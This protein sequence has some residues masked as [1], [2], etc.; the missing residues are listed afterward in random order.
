MKNG[1]VK[2]IL[3]LLLTLAMLTALLPQPA[4][5]AVAHD[6]P[7]WGEAIVGAAESAIVRVKRVFVSSGKLPSDTYS[8]L[9]IVD[10]GGSV[11]QNSTGWPTLYHYNRAAS[12][13]SNAISYD[14]A[15]NT[16]TLNNYN[17]GETF[18]AANRMGDLTINVIGT[19][20]LDGIFGWGDRYGMSFHLIGNGTLNLTYNGLQISGELGDCAISIG[21]ELTLTSQYA[22]GSSIFIGQSSSTSGIT[23]PVN[24]DGVQVETFRYYLTTTINGT[25]YRLYT[26]N[27]TYYGSFQVGETYSLFQLNRNGN[28][29]TIADNNPVLSNVAEIPAE[30]EVYYSDYYRYKVVNESGG[31]L[32][33]VTISPSGTTVQGAP[34]ILTDTVLPNGFVGRSCAATLSATPYAE[35]AALAWSLDSG[36]VP[37]GLTL[38]SDGTFSGT[39]AKAGTYTFSAVVNETGGGLTKRQF[40]IVV[41]ETTIAAT[42]LKPAAYGISYSETLTATPANGGAITWALTAG[43]LPAGLG[44]SE[45]GVISG[46]PT[47]NGSSTFTV[48]ATE[49]G[50]GVASKEFT[51]TVAEANTV[52]YDLAGGAGASGVNYD[53]TAIPSGTAI[54]LPAAPTKS[55]EKGA[56]SFAGWKVTSEGQAK[57]YVYNTDNAFTVNEN[58][59]FTAQWER[60]LSVS[61]SGQVLGWV[62]LY[63]VSGEERVSLWGGSYNTVQQSVSAV[64]PV[65]QMRD[66]SYTSLELHA[67]VD[68]EDTVIASYTGAVNQT[69]GAVTLTDANNYTILKGVTVTGLTREADYYLSSVVHHTAASANKNIYLYGSPI[70]VSAGGTY[71]VKLSG[72]KGSASYDKY[73]WSA[74]NGN[75]TLSDG[76]LTVAPTAISDAVAVSGTVTVNGD[77]RSGVI[78]TAT[79]NVGGVARSVSATTESGGGYTLR[80]I[81]GYAATF[82]VSYQGQQLSVTSGAEMAGNNVPDNAAHSI[83]ALSNTLTVTVTP[84]VV[85]GNETLADSYLRNLVRKNNWGTSDSTVTVTSGGSGK[86]AGISVSSASGTT[87]SYSLD[88]IK[89]N[90]AMLSVSANVPGLAAMSNNSVQLTDS[91][92]SVPFTPALVPGVYV[93]S[94]RAERSADV[95]TAWYDANGGYMGKSERFTIST[96]DSAYGIPCPASNN[97]GAF[98]VVLLPASYDGAIEG[99]AYSALPAGAELTSWD[100]TLEAGKA[101]QMESRVLSAAASENAAFV[102]KPGSTLTASAESFAS[103]NDLI[104]F[105]GHIGLDDG[106]KNGRLTRLYANMGNSAHWEAVSANPKQLVIDGKSYAISSISSGSQVNGVFTFDLSQENIPLPCDYTLYCTPG[107]IAWEMDVGLRADVTYDDGG[108]SQQLIG[109]AVVEKPGAYI[110]TLST[111]VCDEQIAV[112]GTAKPNEAVTIYDNGAIAGTA[113]ADKYG[114]WTAIIDLNG[115]DT[116]YVTTH[117]IHSVSAAGVMSDEMTVFHQPGGAQLTGFTMTYSSYGSGITSNNRTV[118]VGDTYIVAPGGLSDVSFTVTVKNPEQ[119]KVLPEGFNRKVTVKVYTNDGQIRFVDAK[120]T[121]TETVDGATV[122]TFVA[123]VGDLPALV[124][125]AE[126]LMLPVTKTASTL[127]PGAKDNKGPALSDSVDGAFAA[128]MQTAAKNIVDEYNTQNHTNYTKIGEVMTAIARSAPTDADTT[129]TFDDS[130]K[131]SVTLTADE[132]ETYRLVREMYA[133]QDKTLVASNTSFHNIASTTAFLNTIGEEAKTAVASGTERTYN[134]QRSYADKTSLDAAKAR[135]ATAFNAVLGSGGDSL[136]THMGDTTN[137]YDVYGIDDMTYDEDNSRWDGTYSISVAYICDEADGL[138]TEVITATFQNGFSGFD[139]GHATLMAAGA[140]RRLQAGLGPASDETLTASGYAYLVHADGPGTDPVSTNVQVTAEDPWTWGGTWL[141]LGGDVDGFTETLRAAVP[142]LKKAAE[143]GSAIKVPGWAANTVPVAATIM[144][145]VSMINGYIAAVERMEQSDQW[146]KDLDELRSKYCFTLLDMDQKVIAERY[147]KEFR[148]KAAA[149][150]L[151][152]SVMEVINGGSSILGAVWGPLASYLN[153]ASSLVSTAGEVLGGPIVWVVSALLALIALGSGT[154]GAMWAQQAQDAAYDAYQQ[155]Y[156]V[157]N[158]MIMQKALEYEGDD[159]KGEK[160]SK[161]KIIEAINKRASMGQ[162][163]DPSGIVYEGVIENPVAGATATLYYAADNNNN[164]VKESN[165]GSA[166]KLLVANGVRGVTPG[167]PV[168]TTSGDGMFQWFVPEGLWF[169]TAE[170]GALTGNSNGDTAATVTKTVGAATTLLPVLPPQLD[171]NIPL[172]DHSVPYVTDVQYQTDGIYVTFSKYMVDTVSGTNSALNPANYSVYSVSADTVVSV[173]SVEQGSTP[174]NRGTPTTS[175]TRT[176][177]LTTNGTLTAGDS[178]TLTVNNAKSYAGTPMASYAS[179]SGIVSEPDQLAAPVFSGTT[180]AGAAFSGSTVKALMNR[181][182]G[183]TI[184]AENGAKIYYTTDGTDPSSSEDGTTKLYSGP[185]AVSGSMTVKAIAVKIGYTA[186]S[187]ATA[188]ITQRTAGTRSDGSSISDEPSPT[189]APTPTPTPTPSG[190]SD[191]ASGNSSVTVPVSGGTGTINLNV[192]VS[193]GTA[194]VSPI[195]DADVARVVGTGGGNV[196]VVMNLSS[197]GGK[198]ETVSIPDASFDKLSNALEAHNGNDSLT[199]KTANGSV[200]LNEAAASAVA[201]AGG[202]GNV[203]FTIKN[204][205]ADSFDAARRAAVSGKTVAGAYDLGVTSNGS[206][207]GALGGGFAEINVSFAPITGTKAEDHRVYRADK[208]GNTTLVP[209]AVHDGT[210]TVRSDRLDDIVIVYEPMSKAFADIADGAYYTD[211]LTWALANEITNGVGDNR[212]APNGGCTRAQIVTFL[213]RAAGSPQP[214][215]SVSGFADVAAGTWYSS[216]V[217]WAVENG[218]TNGVG[219]GLFG[220]EQICTRAQVATFLCRMNGGRAKRPPFFTDVPGDAWYTG[221]VAWANENGVTNGTSGGTFSPDDDCT[222]GQIVTFLYRDFVK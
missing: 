133:A 170:K 140:Q 124:S 129:V 178:V 188:E 218:I 118:N 50:G 117:R 216:A 32:N 42:S 48:T 160:R 183:L 92:A 89:T 182:G 33:S 201:N 120:Q 59:T 208:N 70:L 93:E 104:A 16:L 203:A 68:G 143:M 114:D 171:V 14:T 79:Q 174:A 169:V 49:A 52:A 94:L 90:S 163:H 217:A 43:S 139:S 47:A 36:S 126:V 91:R 205:G 221:A 2:K 55:D 115:T 12:Y 194:Q 112:E 86:T 21:D 46:T 151:M 145:L 137:Y 116:K 165:S 9:E 65:W 210:L 162:T 45:S 193:G 130:G 180:S 72:V 186:S 61:Y 185:I 24:I 155:C 111:Y 10:R 200:R 158:H 172:V 159:C 168:Q 134:A 211:A 184:T 214:K 109:R 119:L 31:D 58:V 132:Q 173:V 56:L 142:S 197:L 222:R 128:E 69:T 179:S 125:G 66:K 28:T 150:Y 215:R 73:D 138:Y 198:I 96:W 37:D 51:L 98:T 149:Y 97:T 135:V 6:A 196:N 156:M 11:D 147:Y 82:A 17:G 15:S 113:T 152:E 199:L 209:S 5:A 57:G 122:A 13:S 175:Y 161:D 81:P 35:G 110:T 1:I 80:L 54:T 108:S 44:L 153:V 105:M 7:E 219:D 213:W 23:L 26:K 136:V 74:T 77:T 102:T 146:K 176:V 157:T 177:K 40:T 95:F 192:T 20:T 71:T 187:V 154:Y 38:N 212:F 85:S 206:D 106:C 67:T 39:F 63:G 103:E 131:P 18:I 99:L 76:T 25:S 164:L 60:E 191:T 62:S 84:Q 19:N 75:L 64:V 87:Q 22:G 29:Y 148:D 83:T 141:S 144:G 41:K 181:G 121:K 53:S 8:F 30:Y 127:A 3:S 167:D 101:T 189:P 78:V 123:K 204:S 88:F 220:A 166:N 202:A 107:S 34:T 4:W 27:G 195:S 100:V 207:V 190:T